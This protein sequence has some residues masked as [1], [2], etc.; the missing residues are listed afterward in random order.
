MKLAV[1]YLKT[2]LISDY[3]NPN[4]NE[5]VVSALAARPDIKNYIMKE[6]GF[7]S[8]ENLTAR[9]QVGVMCRVATLFLKKHYSRANNASIV[10]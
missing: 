7:D 2:N 5:S 4:N 6:R 3:E 1:I 8:L 9:E 10:A